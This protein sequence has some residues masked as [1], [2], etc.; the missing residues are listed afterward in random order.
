MARQTFPHIR[1]PIPG[2]VDN[3]IRMECDCG[4]SAALPYPAC[5][6]EQL[7]TLFIGHVPGDQRR[8]YVLVDQRLSDQAKPGTETLNADGEIESAEMLPRGNWIMPAQIPCLVMGWRQ[9]D[10]WYIV[11]VREFAHDAPL[12][13]LPLGEVRTRDGKI[14]GCT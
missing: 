14:F 9:T 1:R 10:E 11:T 3:K 8:A 4:W 13:E 7:E 12:I 2:I 5:T 6:Y